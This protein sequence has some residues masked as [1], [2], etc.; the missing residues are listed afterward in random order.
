MSDKAY[1]WEL[2][3]DL[4]DANPE[5]FNRKDLKKYLIALC[6]DVIDMKRE[7]LCWWDDHKVPEEE[8]QTE[9]HTK[10]T[11]LVQFILTSTIVIHTLDDLKQVFV[12]I[13]SCKEFDPEKALRFTMF[14]FQAQAADATLLTR[15]GPGE[16]L[17]WTLRGPL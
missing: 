2:V 9:A 8:R 3:M 16:K 5:R 7:R 17:E 1:G 6:D 12:N 4:K 11:S 15:G 14:W 13:F 10:G